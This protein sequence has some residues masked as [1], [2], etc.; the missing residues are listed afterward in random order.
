MSDFLIPSGVSQVIAVLQ[1]LVRAT[2]AMGD[3][4]ATTFRAPAYAAASLPAVTVADAGR[5]AFVTNARNTGQGAGAGTGC[6]CVVNN[7]GAWVTTWN[8][9]APTT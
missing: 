7:A 9:L 3:Q 8:G 4:Q 5:M 1:D 6:L 2:Y